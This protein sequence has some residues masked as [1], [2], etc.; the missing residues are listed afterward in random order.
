MSDKIKALLPY[1]LLPILIV[2]AV[3]L[4]SRGGDSQQ[5]KKLE[6]YQIVEK[7]D[8]HQI[9]AYELNLGSG[10]LK[11]TESDGKTSGKYTV[12]N[13]SLF[14]EDIHDSVI[15]YNREHKDAPIKCD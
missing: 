6:Y 1:V 3:T 11:Y 13:V 12:P 5:Q 4:F 8:E 15:E 7:F 14:L 9:S 2:T 10:V